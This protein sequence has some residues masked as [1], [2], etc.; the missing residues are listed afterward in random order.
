MN[1][2]RFLAIALTLCIAAS[3][4]ASGATAPRKRDRL[5]AVTGPVRI[6]PRSEIPLTLPG[7]HSYFGNIELDAASDGLVV[8]NE[9]PFERYL[10][11]LQEVPPDWPG[12]ALRA[13]A[14][15]ARTYAMW[16]LAN[17]R[18]GAADLYGF[19]ICA[20]VEC[21]VYAG[22][23]V[24]RSADGRRWAAA[25]ASTTGRTLL[26][27]GRPILAR[28][29][30]TS[31]GATLDN[32]E[33]IPGE[34]AYPY[35]VPVESPW[36]RA[37]PL[38]RWRVRFRR[39]ELQA[40]LERAVLWE[41]SWGRLKEVHTIPSRTGNHY[42]DAVLEGTRRRR[43]VDVATLRGGLR[44]HAPATFPGEYP[45]RWPT[46]SGVLPET[47]PSSRVAIKT[48][49]RI[50]TVVGRGWGHGV[51]M[52]QWGAY[53]L[54]SEGANHEEI[55]THYYSGVE[56]DTMTRRQPIEVG[57]DWAE[58]SVA[59]RGEFDVLDGRGR[60][61]EADAVGTW[62]FSWSDEGIVA[63]DP[64]H[65]YRLPLRVGVVEAP[66]RALPGVRARLTIAVSRPAVVRAV[67]EDGKG[68]SSAK[69][70]DA[71]RRVVAW[72]APGEPGRYVV[73]VEASSG[74]TS[75][76]SDLVEILVPAGPEERDD[77]T[78]QGAGEG[79][80][81]VPVLVVVAVL[82]IGASVG[83]ARRMRA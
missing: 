17:E 73:R 74:G 8:I 27:R 60:V 18:G 28:Y 65:G 70:V 38:Y 83:L 13:Q 77:D 24:V 59:I 78:P 19:D 35:L 15:A 43:I 23:D 54:A 72:R 41:K 50:V 58:S 42:P 9:L 67:T 55:L 30:S 11:G 39:R 12:E 52:S 79:D 25:V 21:Q 49:G 4:P 22:A 3:G 33:A 45:S 56:L 32:A 48:K 14:V 62:R 20:T 5:A 34:R 53:G 63:V 6:V 75:V 7:V 57:I 66:A 10:L 81:V 2:V 61:L 1:V 37:A 26:H 47:L 69:V 46:T 64:P 29:H 36:E 51:G 80:V 76:R 82:L 31:G 68:S 40:I 44:V 16:T 71:G